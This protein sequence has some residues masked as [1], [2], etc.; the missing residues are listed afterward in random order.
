MTYASRFED[1]TKEKEEEEED[2]GYVA[3]QIGRTDKRFEDI[4]VEG[5]NRIEKDIKKEV[6]GRNSKSA[7]ARR[8]KT[9]R[10]ERGRSMGFEGKEKKKMTKG[11][12]CHWRVSEKV[13]QRK[14]RKKGTLG[15]IIE[16][17]RREM[18]PSLRSE[19]EFI[20]PTR[21]VSSELRVKLVNQS[22][23]TPETPRFSVL[24]LLLRWLSSFL[25]GVSVS[26]KE[27]WAGSVEAELLLVKVAKE[28]V[29]LGRDAEVVGREGDTVRVES[30]SGEEGGGWGGVELSRFL[31][32]RRRRKKAIVVVGGLGGMRG[33]VGGVMRVLLLAGMIGWR[34]RINVSVV[35]GSV[36]IE[37]RAGGKGRRV[38]R[39]WVAIGRVDL[40]HRHGVTMPHRRVMMHR[41]TGW[42][43]LLSRVGVVKG[44]E[45]SSDRTVDR[46][47][48]RRRVGGRDETEGGR[49]SREVAGVR[50]WRMR[51]VQSILMKWRRRGSVEAV[52]SPRVDERIGSCSRQPRSA[53]RLDGRMVASGR[54]D[55]LSLHLPRHGRFESLLLLQMGERPIGRVDLV[56]RSEGDGG[57]EGRQ[58]RWGVEGWEVGRQ[59][60]RVKQ[61][62]W[63][64]GGSV[65]V[66]REGGGRLSLLLLFAC[67]MCGSTSPVH[68]S[69]AGREGLRFGGVGGA[70]DGRIATSSPNVNAGGDGQQ[71][72]DGRPSSVR[73]SRQRGLVVRSGV[74]RVPLLLV[75]VVLIAHPDLAAASSRRSLLGRR[76]R[77]LP[78]NAGAD[79]VGREVNRETGSHIDRTGLVRSRRGARVNGWRRAGVTASSSGRESKGE[80]LPFEVD[81][82]ASCFVGLWRVGDGDV[83]A[84]LVSREAK[85]KHDKGL[86]E[87]EIRQSSAKSSNEWARERTYALPSDT[88]CT[89]SRPTTLNLP[90]PTVSTSHVDLGRRAKGNQTM[91]SASVK[92]RDI[93]WTSLSSGESLPFGEKGRR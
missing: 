27:E 73:L 20:L 75:V 55:V 6:E 91:S 74:V 16:G 57:E 64:K 63:R 3:R 62:R 11:I 60:P 72:G 24:L 46:D 23:H 26:V 67:E 71:R 34:S 80:L 32:D 54:I 31:V 44:R 58:G 10:G 37:V 84:F 52:L 14:M 35:A 92:S 81:C 42:W 82:L 87:L 68:L 19:R 12:G 56:R 41:N 8:Q 18:I 76:G 61:S 78:L 36:A 43:L 30:W 28:C 9:K 66:G 85:E 22:Q 53:H 7:R 38:T 79:G 15:V 86:R 45:V 50:G 13:P 49:R 47:A 29:E 4:R 77:S 90:I 2:V 21:N 48:T 40:S 88:V 69:L 5:S 39:V 1:D 65:R 17:G 93:D 25:R 89:P 83:D 70:A 59:R 33:V 51:I